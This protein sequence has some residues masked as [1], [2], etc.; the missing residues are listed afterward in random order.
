MTAVAQ[1]TPHKA[2]R[3]DSAIASARPEIE[4]AAIWSEP[5]DCLLTRLATR[6]AGFTA[7]DVHSH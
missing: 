4:T 5:L 3:R 7:E 1:E 6:P 2:D